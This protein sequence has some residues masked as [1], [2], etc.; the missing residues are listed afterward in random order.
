MRRILEDRL[1]V[2]APSLARRVQPKTIKGYLSAVRSL[3][4]DAD[5]P[6]SITESPIVQRLIRGIKRYHGEKD[7]KPVQPITLSVLLA[8]LS[9]LQPGIIAGHT[10]IYAACCLA[11]AG[12]YGPANSPRARK[13]IQVLTSPAI[14]CSS[15]RHSRTA[16]TSSSLYLA[17][18]PTPFAKV[19]RSQSQ[20]PLAMRRAPSPPSNGCLPSFPGREIP[21][22]LK[23]STGSLCIT[24]LSS[25]VCALPSRLRA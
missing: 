13:T 7:R 1:R 4:V 10:A 22:Y 8:L 23:A 21:R 17:P 20:L 18:K 25:K 14:P 24:T 12:L 15:Y 2:T 5:L 11:Y 6:F 9:Q 3:H 19:S 16:P